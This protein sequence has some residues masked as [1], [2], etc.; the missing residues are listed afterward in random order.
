MDTITLESRHS[1]G[2]YAKRERVMVR[3]QGVHVWDQEGRRYIDCAAGIG[4]A[5]VGHCHPRV[6][7]AIVAQAQTLVTCHEMF[8]NDQRAELLARLAAVLPSGI[9]RLYLG[10]SGAEAVETAIKF[11]RLSTARTGVV[12]AMRG[13]HGRTMGALSATHKEQ[14][15]A[16]FRPLVPDF[17]HVPFNNIAAMR[18]VVDE[19]TAA[20]ILEVVQGESGVRPGQADYFQA[21]RRLCT[22]RGALLI[23]DEVQT[24]FGRTGRWFACEHMDVTPDL[25]C[26]GKAIAGGLPMSAV[27]LGPAVSGLRPGLHGSTFGG[28]PLACAAALATLDVIEREQLVARAEALGAYFQTGLRALNSPLVREVR[29]LGLMIGLELKSR[30]APYAQALMDRGIIALTAGATV[31]RFLPPLTIGRAEIDEVL[32]AVSVV[33]RPVPAAAVSL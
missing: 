16:P 3:G 25:I 4:V 27:G 26:L 32:E 8:F 14:Y 22:E 17:R 21:L 10:N 7:E 5:N 33:L 11:A 29:G 6:T 12:A 30:A 9:E 15:R 31:L 2:V 24:G 13:F 18:E 20:V 23:I 19:K 28:N 1:S